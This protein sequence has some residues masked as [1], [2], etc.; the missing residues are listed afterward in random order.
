MGLFRFRG[1]PTN[2]GRFGPVKDGDILD[3]QPDEEAGIREDKRFEAYE[4]GRA[5]ATPAANPI[6]AEA[7]SAARP[8]NPRT[9]QG[10]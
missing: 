1:E 10:K 5:P 7:D 8:A 4:K 3:L 2:L 6:K 9:V